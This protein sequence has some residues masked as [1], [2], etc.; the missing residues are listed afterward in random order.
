MP[1]TLGLP[2]WRLAT[3]IGGLPDLH[4]LS[5][6]PL[7]QLASIH[8]VGDGTST[9]IESILTRCGSRMSHSAQRSATDSGMSA[10][11]AVA[12]APPAGRSAAART[13][14]T[15]FFSS[16]SDR[17]QGALQNSTESNQVMFS[18]GRSGSPWNRDSF[19]FIKED[20]SA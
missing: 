10:T 17:G 14:P 20:H 18:T 5:R 4:V 12:F 15:E 19:R 11:A 7:L 6:F 2:G 9:V 1:Y 16:L 3:R 13:R 8:Q